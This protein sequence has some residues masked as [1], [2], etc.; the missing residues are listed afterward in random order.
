MKNVRL[1]PNRKA[2]LAMLDLFCAVTETRLLPAVNSPLHHTLR[3]LVDD[4]GHKSR[5]RKTRLKHRKPRR[6]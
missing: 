6:R 4:A 5:R 2:F 1:T 3:W